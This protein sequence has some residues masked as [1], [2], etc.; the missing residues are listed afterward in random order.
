MTFENI[1]AQLVPS[2][3]K[4]ATAGIKANRQRLAPLATIPTSAF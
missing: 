1:I 3:F 4:R 2:P